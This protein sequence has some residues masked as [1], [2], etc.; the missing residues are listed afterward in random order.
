MPWRSFLFWNALGGICWATSVGLAG[1]YAGHAA[2]KL[3]QKVGLGALIA[4]VLGVIVG[5]TLFRWRR[6]RRSAIEEDRSGVRP[7]AD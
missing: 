7:E 5:Y 4:F 3:I 1:Y 6:R 2:E